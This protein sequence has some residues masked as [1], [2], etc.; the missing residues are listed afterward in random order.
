[1]GYSLVRK[2]SPVKASNERARSVRQKEKA[3]PAVL[4]AA[5]QSTVISCL[6]ADPR[7]YS[8]I[9]ALAHIH[10]RG[11]PRLTVRGVLPKTIR[12]RRIV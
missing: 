2:V 5:R 1:M 12:P 6:S 7:P 4:T 9:K 10:R 3:S 11:F 8:A